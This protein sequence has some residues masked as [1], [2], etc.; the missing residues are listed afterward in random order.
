MKIKNMI[1]SHVLLGFFFSLAFSP[2]IAAPQEKQEE[3][4]EDEVAEKILIPEEVKLVLQEGLVQRQGRQDI[5]FNIVKHLYLPARENVHSIFIFKMKNAD[6]GFAPR[7]E[8]PV[9]EKP[10]EEKTAE[11]EKKE[12]P[13]VSEIET[14]PVQLQAN[15]NV[16]LQFHHLNKK[17]SQENIKEVYIPLNLQIEKT[18]YDPE[19]EEI[20]TSAYPLPSGDYLL[21]MAITSLDLQKIGTSYYEFSLSDII[22]FKEKLDTTPVFFVK[23]ITQMASPEMTSEIHKNFFTYSILQIEPK[24]KNVLA[25][26]ENLDVFFFIYGVQAKENG[27]YNIEVNYEVLKEEEKVIRFEPITYSAPIISQP[28]PM[29]KTV[30]IK[31]EGKEEKRESRD[32]GPG[33]Y[34]LSIKIKDNVSGKSLNRNI[35]FEVKE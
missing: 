18:S 21:A 34:T 31:S 13:P 5:P 35:D 25:K 29:K 23:K 15:L 17:E 4:K 22:S 11:E 10:E 28:L 14:L 7:V 12:A 6:M 3:K 19:K 33:Y 32:L 16:F 26:G 1:I 20:Y 2:C 8:V 9:E 24:I 30:L 27:K